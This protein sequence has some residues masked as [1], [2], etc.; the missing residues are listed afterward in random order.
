MLPI[1]F[2]RYAA[3]SLR[4]D[5]NEQ[6]I[7]SF[8]KLQTSRRVRDR[9]GVSF[10]EGVRSFV[11]AVD[12]GVSL[13]EIFFS[14]VLLTSRLSRKLVKQQQQRGTKVTPLTPEQF[15]RLSVARKAS[16]IAFLHR[17]TKGK[18][19]DIGSVDCTCWLVAESIQS[20]GN[21]GTLLRT[22]AAVGGGGLIVVGRHVDPYDPTTVRASTGCFFRQKIITTNVAELAH[23]TRNEGRSLVAA[24]PDG[25]QDLHL[26]DFPK[27]CLIAV[28]NE[29]SGLNGRL[30]SICNQ[31]VRIPM[32]TAVDSLNVGVAGS[33][34]MYEA[35][36]QNNV[37]NT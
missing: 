35:A 20:P 12:S 11:A 22:S 37:L 3:V 24:S 26:A 9:R 18:L 2:F 16:G 27:G 5:M 23:W 13:A 29:R 4:E 31:H 14:S 33:L 19:S 28:G 8:R 17:Q 15:R 25:T 34:L 10:A 36:R 21:L 7:Q 30:S 1:P 32:K 6:A